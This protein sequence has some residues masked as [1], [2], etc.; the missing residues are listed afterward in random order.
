[1]LEKLSGK[2]KPVEVDRLGAV[3]SVRLSG[4]T[5]AT[6]TLTR[7][8]ADGTYAYEV[9]LMRGADGKWRIDNM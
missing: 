3:R 2:T 5:L 6:I 4:D 7:K 8:K 1:M 9:M